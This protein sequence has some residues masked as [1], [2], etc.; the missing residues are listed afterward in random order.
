MAKV[1]KIILVSVMTRVIVEEDASEEVIFETAKSA[2]SNRIGEIDCGDIE[3]I[4]DDKE[5]PYGTF[6]NEK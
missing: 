4:R 2:L 1:A 5:C 3:Y 6:D